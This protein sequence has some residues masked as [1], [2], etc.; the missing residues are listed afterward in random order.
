[1]L[2][3]TYIEMRNILSFGNCPQIVQLDR[4]PL[5]VITGV[6]NDAS[7]DSSESRNGV[8]KS[9][10]IQAMHFALYGKS[11]DN[12]I[13][14]NNLVN[15]INKKNCEV[16]LT[17]FKNGN[18]YQIHRGRNPSFLKFYENNVDVD[19]VDTAQGE[20]KDTQAEIQRVVE[21]SQDMFTQIVTL[22]TST[23]SFL[24]LPAS[25][26]RLIIEELLT[27]SKLSEKAEKLKLLNKDAKETIEREKFK[28]STVENSNQK[29]MD[30][31]VSIEE[32]SSNFETQKS[33]AVKEYEKFIETWDHIDFDAELQLL[34]ENARISEN[35][36]TFLDLETQL[37]RI[38]ES[39][40]KWMNQ[41][42]QKII[43]IDAALVGLNSIDIV[44]EIE[45]HSN[46]KLWN[47]LKVIHDRNRTQYSTIQRNISANNNQIN[48][49]Q[50]ELDVLMQHMAAVKSKT[51]PMCL[52]ALTDDSAHLHDSTASQIQLKKTSIAELEVLKDELTQ[53]LNS[54][55]IFDMPP[56]ITTF[57]KN[58]A[59]AHQ[60]LFTI[61]SLQKQRSE[62]Q[63]AQNPYNH[64]LDDLANKINM[65]TMMPL[66]ISK[67][68]ST[69]EVLRLRLEL[70]HKK[71]CLLTEK[72]AIN[73]YMNQITTLHSNLVQIDYNELNR[74]R[75]LQEHQEFLVKLLTDKNSFVRKRI[76]D[77]N[78]SFL[79]NR[80]STYMRK[81]LSQHTVLFIN[82]LSVDIT[83]LGESYDFD[84]LSRG[85]KNRVI[86]AL[87]LAFR[88]TF[89]SLVT[90]VNALF[91]D[92]YFDQGMDPAG[93]MACYNMIQDLSRTGNKNCFLI[94]HK[95]E[96]QS[97][98]NNELTVT[99]E[100][101]FSTL[102]Y[103][104]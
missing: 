101:S 77:T 40:Q 5:T 66:N 18:Q 50:K 87:S 65:Q 95:E 4:D 88:D 80:L 10:I 67:F 54:I 23:E 22:T 94:T 64:Q 2:K 6:N 15:K 61:E 96:L 44:Q 8:G 39:Y 71:S 89:E 1:M 62:L 104:D 70:D 17:F 91:I 60:H 25:K 32:M 57:Y 93:V 11:V 53:E 79:N 9:S 90:S 7:S 75:K 100:N 49:A 13:K 59:E 31:I 72:A 28:I 16:K 14:L 63:E 47:E 68:N 48:K 33:L 69:D 30:S 73:P 36:K 24:G 27:I 3:F 29:I 19:A 97:K 74:L 92:E 43:E 78:L 21:M 98:C 20:N 103:G 26:Q 45:N 56:V 99:M 34:Q 84:N 46:K 38:N 37:L 83:K 51:C 42:N 58:D 76:I 81:S 86:I 55:E 12:R 82:D 41:T 85:E 52:T 35:N 102:S